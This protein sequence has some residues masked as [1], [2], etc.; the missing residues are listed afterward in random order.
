MLLLGTGTRVPAAAPAT[1]P[2]GPGKVAPTGKRVLAWHTGISSLWLDPQEQPALLTPTN[3]L[4]ALHD[5]LIKNSRAQFAAP[6]LAERVDIAPD[7]TSAT[8]VLRPGLKFHNAEPVTSADVQFTYEHYRGAQAAVLKEKTDKIEISDDRTIRFHFKAPFLDFPTI[9]G[10]GASG[11]GW[12]VPA[13]YYQQVGPDAF[14]QKP[15]GAGPYKLVHQEPGVRVEFEAFADYYRPVHTKQLVM[16][17]VPEAATRVAMLER[18]EAD[19]M[20]L[21]PGELIDTVKKIPGVKLAPTLGGPFWLDFPGMQDPKNPFHDKRVREAVSLALDRQALS[22]A[23]TGGYAPPLGNWI[24]DDWPGAIKWPAFEHNLAKAQHLLAEAGYPNG[25]N[26]DWLA[27]FPPYFSLGER[28]I[29]Q[30]LQIGIRARLQTMERGTFLQ[31][32]ESGREAFPGVQMVLIVSGTP[33]DW[34]GRYRAYLQC[35]GFASRTCVPELDAKFQHYEKS[36]DPAQCQQLAEEIQRAILEN[37]YV[38]PVFRLAFINAIGPR[39]VAEKWQD[40]FPSVQSVYAYP[41]EDIRL[42]P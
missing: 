22:D 23:E 35:K 33:G 18:G 4:Y 16:I 32:L 24:P 26:V 28:I 1:S 36:A 21:V 30:L 19:I 11:A 31:R 6:A 40:V 37:Y 13:K 2:S 25:F 10:T 15:I 41:W 34:A 14:K 39:V 29:G 27:P 3:F 20:Y 12:V 42:K 17:S 7:F 38:V 8:C 9:Y 5:A